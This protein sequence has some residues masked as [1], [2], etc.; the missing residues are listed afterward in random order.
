MM[1]CSTLLTN[2][3]KGIN[4][5]RIITEGLFIPFLG[6]AIGA[7]AVCFMKKNIDERIN[8]ALIG[9]AAGVMTAASVWS[10]LIPSI[11]QVSYLGLFA[12]VP[13][14]AGLFLGMMFLIMTDCFS[15]ILMNESGISEKRKTML[16][17]F[18][19]VIHNIPEGMAVGIAFSSLSAQ[20]GLSVSDAMALSIGIAVQ[21][22]PEGAIISLPLASKGMKKGKACLY[23][24]LSGAVEPLAGIV[25][26]LLT[27]VISPLLPYMLSFAAGCMLFVVANEL[28]PGLNGK[29]GSVLFMIGFAVMMILD[30]ALG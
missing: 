17:V 19:V 16:L 2:R 27:A 1:L 9:F 15:D 28:M 25:T 26:I 24:V 7:A 18:A 21:N 5:I 4:M 29:T 10:L 3:A 20:N 22:L 23:G 8:S 13:A 30:V 6:T 12:F 11:E 14:A